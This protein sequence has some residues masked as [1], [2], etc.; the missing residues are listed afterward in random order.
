[1]NGL[2]CK[3]KP[4]KDV[5]GVMESVKGFR[6]Q[7]SSSPKPEPILRRRKE[8]RNSLTLQKDRGV[9]WAFIL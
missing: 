5:T 2:T 9:K 3:C 1:M 8:I 7:N 4:S 6:I